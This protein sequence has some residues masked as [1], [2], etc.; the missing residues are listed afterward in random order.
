M[1]LYIQIIFVLALAKFCL[2]AA[3]TG[4][5]W[6][7]ACYAF[8]AAL[9]S[10]ALYPTVI[11]QPATV[12]TNLLADRELVTDGA[13]LT[14]TEAILGIFVSV[15]LLSNYFKPKG[16]RRKSVFVLKVVPGILW[17]FAVAYFEL[18]FFRQRVGA[19]FGATAAIY[20][21]IVF[22]VVLLAAGFIH[23]F[24]RH[25][26]MKLELKIML[27]MGILLIGLLVNA[28]AADSTVVYATVSNVEWSALAA[29]TAGTACFF[30]LGLL[31]SKINFKKL[32]NR[33]N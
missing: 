33:H 8:F 31:L 17:I 29:L 14:T 13:V 3:M 22:A 26:S 9:V 24:V 18:L 21:G 4:R 25:E 20:A 6:T 2:K 16:Q 12:I 28:S 27:N 10:L 7:M 1:E 15:F 5:F 19:D 32:I 30:L 11:E 23:L